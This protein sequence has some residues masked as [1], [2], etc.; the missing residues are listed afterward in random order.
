MLIIYSVSVVIKLSKHHIV[1][2]ENNYHNLYY[3][4]K[5][6]KRIDCFYGRFFMT[7]TDS[8][9]PTTMIAT[10]MAATAGTKYTSDSL[11]GAGVGAVVGSGAESTPNAV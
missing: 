8:T 4:I 7:S 11:S 9:N 3:K 1:C 5:K 10:I 2:L 6:E